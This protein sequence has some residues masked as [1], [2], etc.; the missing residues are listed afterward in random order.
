VANNRIIHRIAARLTSRVAMD[1]ACQRNDGNFACAA[2]NVDNKRANWLRNR[3][4]YTDSC[5]HW[6]FY[7]KHITCTSGM[8]GIFNSALFNLGNT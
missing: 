7:Q 1:Y 3:Q 5:S 8:R 4:T 2:T 6:F